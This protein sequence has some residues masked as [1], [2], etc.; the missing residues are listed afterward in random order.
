MQKAA[1]K[2]F[3][4]I[5]AVIVV[6]IVAAMIVFTSRS[7]SAAADKA[8]EIARGVEYIK[9]SEA[10]DVAAV[11]NEIYEMNKTVSEK[12][13]EGIDADPNYVWTALSQINTVYMGDSRTLAYETYGFVDSSRCMG[14]NESTI[15]M[16]PDRYYELQVIN[17]RLIVIAFG[18]NDIGNPW[19]SGEE[20]AD[21]LMQ[22]VD[23]I[24]AFLP[25]CKVYIQSCILP[26]ISIDERWPGIYD[27]SREWHSAAGEI[28]VENGY[29]YIDIGDLVEE[30]S[31]LFMDD[32]VHM[33]AEFY[34]VLA[35]TILNRYMSDMEEE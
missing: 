5:T 35:Q 19:L 30:Y 16:I 27:F 6:V 10:G 1:N 22:Y 33:V 7:G 13:Q 32:G 8:A 18:L 9:K 12:I 21:T 26:R 20:W 34:P 14:V 2:K 4:I 25:E 15:N 3:I 28:F 17:P 24:H 23:E 11:E 31:Y 29:D